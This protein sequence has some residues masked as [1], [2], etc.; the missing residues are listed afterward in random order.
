MTTTR[1]IVHRMYQSLE[2]AAAMYDLLHAHARGETDLTED[3]L[4]NVVT[5]ICREARETLGE[6]R[7]ET[8]PVL[9]HWSCW[10]PRR[11]P[12]GQ[13]GGPPS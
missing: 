6:A 12:L 1:K 9:P 11:A 8:P 3:Q 4:A 10:A 2:K 5:E 13:D 7:G